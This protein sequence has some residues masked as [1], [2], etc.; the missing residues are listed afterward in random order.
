MVAIGSNIEESGRR[1]NLQNLKIGLVP[2]VH[3]PMII[4]ESHLR[5]FN[6]ARSSKCCIA[7][8]GMV[9]RFWVSTILWR[10]L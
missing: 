1:L 4:H 5:A 8:N 3:L 9:G 6:D 7:V 10:V 2:T